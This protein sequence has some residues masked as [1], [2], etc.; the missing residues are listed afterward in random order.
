MC[1]Q[2]Y[3]QNSRY[4]NDYDLFCMI[5]IIHFLYGFLSKLKILPREKKLFATGYI[6]D[7]QG[8]LRQHPKFQ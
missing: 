7:N 4:Q 3:E 5:P 1:T 6:E 8:D 2:A